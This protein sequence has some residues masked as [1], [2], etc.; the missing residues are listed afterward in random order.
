MIF[1]VLFKKFFIILQKKVNFLNFSWMLF[2]SLNAK[3][4]MTIESTKDEVK[5]GLKI[6]SV[7]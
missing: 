4:D 7:V 5:G 2:F 1:L 6:F 3:L